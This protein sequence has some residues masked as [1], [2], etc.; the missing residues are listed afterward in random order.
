[1]FH[2]I[3]LPTDISY[4]SSGG[5]SFLTEV[6]QMAGG[7]EQRNVNWERP[8]ERWAIGYGP[9]HL[10]EIDALRAFF[11]AREGRAHSFRFKNPDDFEATDEPMETVAGETDEFQLVHRYDDGV[12]TYDRVITKPVEDTIT[13]YDDGVDVTEYATIDY[14]TGIVSLSY[15]PGSASEMTAT[16]EFDIPVRFDADDFTED[17][18]NFEIRSVEIPIIEVNE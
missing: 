14:L 2:D 3:Q 7:T 11:Y 8:R 12:V 15:V 18:D 4:R 9:H 16:F 5:P 13:I 1:M 6:V 10:E 17:F